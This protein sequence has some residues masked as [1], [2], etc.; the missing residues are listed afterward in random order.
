MINIPLIFPS[1]V[2]GGLQKTGKFLGFGENLDLLLAREHKGKDGI[3]VYAINTNCQVEIE[4]PEIIKGKD[5][6]QGVLSQH[7]IILYLVRSTRIFYQKLLIRNPTLRS[8]KIEPTVSYK[9]FLLKKY[10]YLPY[11]NVYL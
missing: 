6:L 7:Y 10:V 4:L 9:L 8:P 11:C 1:S 3:S 2:Q 5:K